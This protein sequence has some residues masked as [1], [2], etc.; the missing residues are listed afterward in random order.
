[1]VSVEKWQPKCGN[2]T[3]VMCIYSSTVKV[4]IVMRGHVNIASEIDPLNAQCSELPAVEYGDDASI[5]TL[6]E[7]EPP[8]VEKHEPFRNT[9]V[10]PPAG[11]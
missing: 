2:Q 6:E 4:C 1:M 5:P 10:R 8:I 3:A 11:W 7:H 9:R